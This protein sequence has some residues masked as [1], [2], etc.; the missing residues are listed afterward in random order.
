MFL[1]A[2][3]ETYAHPVF[4]HAFVDAAFFDEPEPVAEGGVEGEVDEDGG[5]CERLGMFPPELPVVVEEGPGD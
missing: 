1:R 2:A 5:E 4:A 3:R